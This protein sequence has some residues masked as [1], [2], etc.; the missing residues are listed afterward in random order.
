MSSFFAFPLAVFFIFVAPL[1][2]FLH[3]RNKGKAGQGLSYEDGQLLKSL[4]ERADKMQKRIETLEKIL[5]SESP[6]WRER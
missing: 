6:S 2:L 3:Y 5:D 1:W 4:T